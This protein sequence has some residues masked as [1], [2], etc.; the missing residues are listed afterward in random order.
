MA[1][2]VLHICI[3]IWIYGNA[4]IWI[5]ACKCECISVYADAELLEAVDEIYSELE[6]QG[7]TV[8][9]YGDSDK[10]NSFT[11]VLADADINNPDPS[12]RKG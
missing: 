4:R 1:Q 11:K 12:V 5:Y 6:A 9:V 10:Y 2:L 8:F 7:I 3:C